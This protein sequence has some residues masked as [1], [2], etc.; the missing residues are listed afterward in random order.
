MVEPD[1]PHKQEPPQSK[2]DN[3][4]KLTNQSDIQANSEIDE[5]H[6]DSTLDTESVLRR[7]E[8]RP[9][10][11]GPRAQPPTL[12]NSN[13]VSWDGQS[14]APIEKIGRYILLDKLG[15]GTYGVVHR[16]RDEVLGRFVALKLLTR[17]ERESEVDS[18]LSEARVLA[19]LDHP[20]IVP[21]F[22][23]GKTPS[24]SLTSFRSWCP[25][26]HLENES[27]GKAARL[28]KRFESPFSLRT[29]WITCIA[30]E[31][32]IATSSRATFSQRR[33]AMQ[34]SPTLV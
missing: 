16:A 12:G 30:K 2:D 8:D 11:K 29:R 19:S 18:W 32:C 25:A 5:D 34:S 28:K 17:F 23:I 13:Q 6:L 7:G 9:L 15:A 10:D 3:Y 26:A 21:V 4:T 27:L 33:K 14:N 1:D 22:D 20:A 31:S 24:D